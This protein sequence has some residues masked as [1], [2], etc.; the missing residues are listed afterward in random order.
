MKV[1]IAGKHI[2]VPYKDLKVKFGQANAL[3]IYNEKKA[4]QN[5]KS[6]TDETTYFMKHPDC[7]SEDC[8]YTYRCMFNMCFC[9]HLNDYFPWIGI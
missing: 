1:G 2:M 3:T 4:L 9:E 6:P 8:K 5:N 7:K